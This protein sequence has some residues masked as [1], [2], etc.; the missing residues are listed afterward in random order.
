MV[1][2]V[3]MVMKD[4]ILL[5]VSCISLIYTCACVRGG[6]C[7]LSVCIIKLIMLDYRHLVNHQLL[8]VY[9]HCSAY[10]LH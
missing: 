6:N 7:H 1:F 4:Y 5:D 3:T 2:V 8:P 10:V 9:T